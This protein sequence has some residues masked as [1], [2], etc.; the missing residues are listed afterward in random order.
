MSEA[1][2]QVDTGYACFCLVV[3]D[4]VVV[5]AAPIAKWVM[6]KS[7]EYVV[8]YFRRKGASVVEVR[9]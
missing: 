3:R 6:G 5:E 4:G 9:R 1:L 2:I 7:V 8:S